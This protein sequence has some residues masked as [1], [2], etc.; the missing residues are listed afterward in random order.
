MSQGTFQCT[1]CGQPHP[2]PPLVYGVEAPAWYYTVPEHERRARTVLTGDQ[3]IIDDRQFFILGR[4]EIPIIGSEETFCWLAWVSLS[5]QNYDRACD[6]WSL[7]GR[8]AEPPYFGWLS[9]ALPY[10][11][12]TVGL[13]TLV[14]TRPVGERPFVELEPTDHPL[15]VEQRAGIRPERV[16]QIAE[17]MRHEFE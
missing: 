1:T 9:S 11:P 10:E 3:C 14:H 16:R 12:T 2:G 17:M 4:V 6:L 5:E 8:E 15:A 7:P 13:K